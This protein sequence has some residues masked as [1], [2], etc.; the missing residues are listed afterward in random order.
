V[1]RERDANRK[2]C[3]RNAV[4]RES[5]D[6]R[7][8]WQE[9]EMSRKEAYVES[10]GVRKSWQDYG[11]SREKGFQKKNRFHGKEMPRKLT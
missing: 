10:G 4:S 1:S 7:K 3:R 6:T 2:R 11:M 5:G 8:G 9:K